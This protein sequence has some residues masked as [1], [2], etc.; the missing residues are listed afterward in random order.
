ML[1]CDAAGRRDE[2]FAMDAMTQILNSLKGNIPIATLAATIALTFLGYMATYFNARILARKKDQ[3][4]LVNK[5][6]HEF[7]GP[8]YVSCKVGRMAFDTLGKKLSKDVF[9]V[10]EASEAELDVW[11]VWMST[12]F[13]PLND[14]REKLII[15]KAHLI[16]EEEMPPCLLDFVTHVVGYKAVLVNWSKGDHSEKTSLIAFPKALDEY[17]VASYAMLKNQQARLL[18]SL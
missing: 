13:M 18:R 15:E 10:A 5:R 9:R 6:L 2:G 14:L 1:L 17:A 4:E 7:Y 11:F 8:L 16:I 3:L 12:V